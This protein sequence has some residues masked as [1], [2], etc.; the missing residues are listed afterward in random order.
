MGNSSKHISTSLIVTTYNW[1]QALALSLR[2]AFAQSL[3]PGEIIVADDGSAGD[4]RQLVDSLRPLCPVP[5]VH[6]WHED[7]GFRLSAIRNKA[8]ARAAGDYIIQTDGDI[9]LSP[10][11]VSDHV[12]LAEPGF[13]VCGSR[14]KLPREATER[15][16]GRGEARLRLW[17]LPPAYMPNALRSRLLRRFMAT[18]YARKVD[19]LRGCNMA[20]WKAD[21][22]KVNGYNE[23]LTQWGHEDGE[24]A[25]RLH[26][27]GVRKKALKMG[28]VAYH[29]WHSEASKANEQRHFDELARVI[30]G[31][32][33]WCANGIDKYL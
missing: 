1:P 31:R 22:V 29:L 7:R 21:A 5:L 15:L 4:T 28:G 33:T 11:F 20:F 2:S 10:R 30:E 19:H 6:V 27:A 13:F 25:Y 32:L 9:I 3:P 14:V 24:F 17:Q 8:I 26:F 23:D 18:R 12:E 16:M